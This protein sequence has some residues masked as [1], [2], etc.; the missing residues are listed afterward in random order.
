MDDGDFYNG[1]KLKEL[2]VEIKN[3]RRPDLRSSLSREQDPFS[4][5]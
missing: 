3:A 2:L 5:R 4:F 1:S